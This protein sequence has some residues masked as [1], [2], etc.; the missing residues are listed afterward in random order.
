MELVFIL[1]ATSWSVVEKFEPTQPQAMT[2]EIRKADI[3]RID[4]FEDMW[5]KDWIEKNKEVVK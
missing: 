1:F 2:V 4:S 5:N 3:E